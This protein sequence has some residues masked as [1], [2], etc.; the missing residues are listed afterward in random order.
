MK[1]YLRYL[2][3]LMSAIILA[4]PALGVLTYYGG[5]DSSGAAGDAEAEGGAY[6]DIYDTPNEWSARYGIDAEAHSWGIGTAGSYTS[7]ALET[8]VLTPNVG[9]IGYEAVLAYGGTVQAFVSQNVGAGYADAYADI[10]SYVDINND[11]QGTENKYGRAGISSSASLAENYMW[12]YAGTNGEASASASGVAGYNARAC[13]TCAQG[14]EQ[15]WGAVAGESTSSAIADGYCDECDGGYIR[16]AGEAYTYGDLHTGSSTGV[17]NGQPHSEYASSYSD[18]DS[19][20]WMNVKEGKYVS[21]ES[22]T[23]GF[24]MSGAWDPS[25]AKDFTKVQGSNENAFSSVSGDTSVFVEG[26]LKGDSAYSYADLYSNAYSYYDITGDRELETSGYFDTYASV[27]R[28]AAYVKTNPQRITAVGYITDATYDAVAR[29]AG[30]KTESSADKVNV[31]SGAHVLNR[32]TFYSMVDPW[33]N[34]AEYDG[35]NIAAVTDIYNDQEGPKFILSATMLDD[36]GSYIRLENL[37]N[38][39]TVGTTEVGLNIDNIDFMN[40]IEG[41]SLVNNMYPVSQDWT[42]TFS[43][44]PAAQYYEDYDRYF[45]NSD[46]YTRYSSS[47]IEADIWT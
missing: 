42:T 17:W 1:A 32:G 45:D 28:T 38:T 20:A 8:P 14:A 7:H 29:Q 11:G 31:A 21:S 44:V 24:A 3:V 30:I 19:Y 9:G 6:Y 10:Y 25:T 43:T 23:S 41:S 27:D 2:I 15:I 34:Y 40:W 47:E 12:P 46:M 13:P 22:T 4:S 39:V 37:D 35:G 36:S 18:M 33:S 26:F 5:F 16:N